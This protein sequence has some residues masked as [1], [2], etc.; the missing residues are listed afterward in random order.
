[1]R[2]T[3][4]SM[5]KTFKK[6]IYIL[7]SLA[8]FHVTQ[9]AWSVLAC[10]IAQFFFIHC[11]NSIFNRKPY[12]LF[13]VIKVQL[14]INHMYLC[15]LKCLCM[16]WILFI[17]YIPWESFILVYRVKYFSS[18]RSLHAFIVFWNSR[19]QIWSRSWRIS[20]TNFCLWKIQGKKSNGHTDTNIKS[21]Q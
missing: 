7:A 17:L 13:C 12:Y 6:Q 19:L 18:W 20:R 21:N 10:L 5:R 14:E 15:G 16:H 4:L 9:N 11:L 3:L 2:F 1:M 8:D